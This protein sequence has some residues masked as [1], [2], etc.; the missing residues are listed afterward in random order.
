MPELMSG[1]YISDQQ[2]QEEYLGYDDTHCEHGTFV[3]GWAGPD[4][5]CGWCED[6]TPYDEYCAIMQERATRRSRYNRV[7]QTQRERA[8]RYVALPGTG[9]GKA[10]A[11]FDSI[12]RLSIWLG[13]RDHWR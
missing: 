11:L 4:Y 10:P 8:S 13:H 2:D 5:M 9:R 12:V 6:G 1:E 7:W 3:G